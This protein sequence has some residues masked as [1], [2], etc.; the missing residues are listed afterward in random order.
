MGVEPP[1]IVVHR[2]L[3]PHR[4]WGRKIYL[5]RKALKTDLDEPACGSVSK[6]LEARSPCSLS[7][8]GEPA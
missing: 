6:V 2:L 4:V 3:A 5:S 7:L 1:A 8:A